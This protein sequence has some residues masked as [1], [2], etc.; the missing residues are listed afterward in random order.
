MIR[1]KPR[2]AKVGD[3]VLILLLTNSNE[4]L[5]QWRGPYIVDSCVGAKD[6]RV[7]MGSKTKTYYLNMLKKYIAGE[8]EV[9]WYMQVTTMMLPQQQSE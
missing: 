8:L 2:Y 3:Q 1:T 4:L 7:K 9:M 5:M 6:Y